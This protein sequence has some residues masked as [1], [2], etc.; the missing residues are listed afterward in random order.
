MANDAVN[1]SQLDT[2]PDLSGP[3][4][5]TGINTF[6]KT[7]K[8]AKGPNVASAAAL[9]LGADGNYF[10]ITGTT[11][12]TSIATVGVGT[13]I[14]LHFNGALTLTHNAT[15][16][17]LPNGGNN[18]VTAAGD[19]AE[20]V[21]YSTGNWRRTSYQRA[22]P[23]GTAVLA[24][25]KSAGTSPGS[26]SAGS[27]VT[28]DLNTE[29]SDPQGI[30]PAP[31]GNTFTP[32]YDCVCEWTVPSHRTDAFQSRLFNVTDNVITGVGMSSYASNS[33]L[34]S[35]TSYGIAPVVAGKRYRVE[36]RCATTGAGGF[37]D[38]Y[39]TEQYT[40]VKLTRI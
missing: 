12:I 38:G 13:W 36:N 7:Q 35:N 17:V 27:W 30:V 34:T 24:D 15:S 39:G 4:T 14:K 1:K 9:A 40:T 26:I 6:T 3:N 37:A 19:E 2:K 10:D 32:A 20:F 25:Q 5:F 28:R 8:W 22:N 18:I 21:E 31:S 33:G 23:R 16:L 11:M 29:V